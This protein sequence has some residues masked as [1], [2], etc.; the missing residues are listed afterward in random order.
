MF[1][2]EIKGVR[3]QVVQDDITE[4]ST[5]AVVN[6]ANSQLQLGAGVAGAI[7]SKGGDSIQRE[8]DEIGGAELG[9]AVITGGGDLKAKYVIHTVGPRYN[10]DPE[11]SKNLYSAVASALDVAAGNSVSS[12]A[13]PAISTG[14]YGYPLEDAAEI[15]VSAVGDYAEKGG[16]YPSHIVLCLYSSKDYEIFLREMK[17]RF[18]D[19]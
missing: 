1:D 4:M 3:I 5:E 13:I 19:E 7:R 14:V 2:K 6:A 17:K 9:T 16:N 12:I 18:P 15:I 10:Q 11:P 8:C